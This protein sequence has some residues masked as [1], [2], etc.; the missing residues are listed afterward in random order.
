M[1]TFAFAAALALSACAPMA[2]Q[3]PQ[4]RA[5]A[6][7]A[8]V[9]AAADR[10]AAEE[11]RAGARMPAEVLAFAE[12]APGETVG[13]FIMGSGYFTRILSAAVGPQGKVY[14]FQP[15]EFVTFRADYAKEQDETVAALANTDGVRGPVAEPPFF[16]QL[17]TIITIQNFHDLYLDPFEDDTASRAVASLYSAL[18]PGGTLVVIDH[19]AAA[20]SGTSAVDSLHRI[21]KRTV[22]DEVTAGGFVL[23]GESDLFARPDDPRTANVFD[24]GIRGQTDQFMLRFRK[25]V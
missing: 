7:Y 1:K 13:D 17:D 9:L 3:A 10:P 22:V 5:V 12:I 15:N 11:A 24:D 25:P 23:D 21:D 20:G 14:A 19:S 16:G 6:Y 4:P 8:A 2:Y 18:K